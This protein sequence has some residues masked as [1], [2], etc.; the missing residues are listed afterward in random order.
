MRVVR[1]PE[2]GRPKWIFE[3]LQRLYK[4][5]AKACEQARESKHKARMLLNS[6]DLQ[7][8]L[9]NTFDHFCRD[10]EFRFDFVQVS[11]THNPI[12]S[13]FGGTY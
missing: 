13:D 6:D 10:I 9:H 4:E 12:P 2:K 1:V 11:F 8:Y 7:P 5:I 3:Q